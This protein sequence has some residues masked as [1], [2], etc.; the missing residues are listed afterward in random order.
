VGL[1]RKVYA[2][3]TAF[4]FLVLSAFPKHA[5]FLAFSA[6][7]QHSV[8]PLT[9]K[10]SIFYVSKDLTKITKDAASSNLLAYRFYF[11]THSSTSPIELRRRFT[12]ESVFSV[13][14]L[15][16]LF[17]IKFYVTTGL[18]EIRLNLVV[19]LLM[20]FGV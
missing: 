7:S 11:F 13:Q 14:V 1:T 16:L 6:F 8:G 20:L 18:T 15:F 2:H 5:A 4:D 12:E 9:P 19:I 3:E 17:P 10:A